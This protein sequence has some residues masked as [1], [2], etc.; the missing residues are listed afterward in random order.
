MPAWGRGSVWAGRPIE[1]LMAG[2]PWGITAVD[3]G[4]SPGEDASMVGVISR[5]AW[6]RGRLVSGAVVALSAL[7]VGAPASSQC[8]R[9]EAFGAIV[10]LTISRDVC[11]ALHA[12][13]VVVGSKEVLTVLHAIPGGQCASR[14]RAEVPVTGRAITLQIQPSQVVPANVREALTGRPLGAEVLWAD[15]TR[16]LALIRVTEG[17]LGLPTVPLMSE[18]A[19]AATFR[20][21]TV[22]F[23]DTDP[24]GPN[25]LT[26]RNAAQAPIDFVVHPSDRPIEALQKDDR[27]LRAVLQ[28]PIYLGP[29]FSVLEGAHVVFRGYSGGAV[30]NEHGQLAALVDVQ[31]RVDRLAAVWVNSATGAI[32]RPADQTA[33]VNALT[34]GPNLAPG[35]QRVALEDA[36]DGAF[37][38]RLPLDS[39]PE[40]RELATDLD[41]ME[42]LM[43]ELESDLSHAS[44]APVDPSRRLAELVA[45][46]SDHAGRVA[47]GG[48]GCGDSRGR[49]PALVRAMVPLYRLRAHAGSLR[50]VWTAIRA[51][52]VAPD[53]PPPGAVPTTL[54]QFDP[55][56]AGEL[57]PRW[58]MVTLGMFG[59][60]SLA[61]NPIEQ[62][63]VRSQCQAS[64]CLLPRQVALLMSPVERADPCAA[65]PL[66]RQAGIAGAALPTCTGGESATGWNEVISAAA[67]S[68]RTWFEFS[69]DGVLQGSLWGALVHQQ[70]LEPLSALAYAVGIHRD[71]VAQR[72]RSL[73]NA[74][75]EVAKVRAALATSGGAIPESWGREIEARLASTEQ[76]LHDLPASLAAIDGAHALSEQAV[77]DAFVAPD[78]LGT[79]VT[80]RHERRRRD[81]QLEALARSTVAPT[82]R[83]E[84]CLSRCLSSIH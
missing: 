6:R 64:P 47:D 46:M 69:R 30:F 24:D 14:A 67:L 21:C 62:L 58:R 12:Q 80:E 35:V 74:D 26:D 70:W 75:E 42:A 65:I 60:A 16:D 78:V 41:Q 32:G 51:S 10:H 79:C 1:T 73:V 2:D 34:S 22:L 82:A 29:R 63:M 61:L 38:A 39:C 71:A 55:N 5:N 9:R 48:P 15:V 53:P 37:A 49:V 4:R 31:L 81:T 66:I 33:V 84:G 77:F 56:A 25:P 57:A 44:A 17:A 7:L 54:E 8:L 19:P 36:V 13:G 11:T 27:G 45:T 18:E 40:V 76:A 83:V 43:D 72:I 68:G 3:L 20:G 28:G 23:H 50:T 52:L 59:I